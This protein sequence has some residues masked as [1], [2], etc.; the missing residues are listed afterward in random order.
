MTNVLKFS[1]EAMLTIDELYSDK[2]IDFVQFTQT[3]D[4]TALGFDWAGGDTM[5]KSITTVVFIGNRADVWFGNTFAYKV[6]FP[7]DKFY[8]DLKM[9]RMKSVADSKEYYG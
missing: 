2:D 6:S 8:D 3:W 7:N 1:I 5:I 9:R 4:S